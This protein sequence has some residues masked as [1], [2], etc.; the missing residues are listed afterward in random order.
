[1]F[2]QPPPP[3][4]S[5]TLF[6]LLGFVFNQL[7]RL[8][9]PLLPPCPTSSPLLCLKCGSGSAGG[10]GLPPPRR[11]G[12]SSWARGPGAQQGRAG[13]SGWQCRGEPEPS[14][15]LFAGSGT[16]R[17]QE[18]ARAGSTPGAAPGLPMASASSRFRRIFGE[19]K[20]RAMPCPELTAAVRAGAGGCGIPAVARRCRLLARGTLCSSSRPPVARPRYQGHWGH[21]ASSGLAQLGA[22]VG[23]RRAAAA[24]GK[25]SLGVRLPKALQEA[26]IGGGPAALSWSGAALCQKAAPAASCTPPGAA[27]ALPGGSA[28]LPPGPPAL[29]PRHPWGTQGPH[30]IAAPLLLRGWRALG[31]PRGGSEGVGSNDSS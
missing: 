7:A 14:T 23:S 5:A 26:G 10:S 29:G 17:G 15:E 20:T 9:K 30:G 21:G 27:P 6:S 8:R 11:L 4:R 31:G 18:E 3:L 22:A 1:M 2:S 16:P 24:R 25:P 12:G 13:V 28:L 19:D